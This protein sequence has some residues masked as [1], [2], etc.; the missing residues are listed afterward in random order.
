MTL[1]KARTSTAANDVKQQL[2]PGQSSALLQELHLLTRDGKLNADALRKL[3][4][5]NHL[6]GF[7][8]APIDDVFARHTDPVVVDFGSGN[9]YLGF[10]VYELMLKDK[11]AGRLLSVESRADLVL[12]GQQRA[13]RLSYARMEFVAAHIDSAALPERIHVATALHACDTATDDAM[14]VAIT[15]KADHIVM[16]PC[17]QAEVAG[18]LKAGACH[19]D[20]LFRFPH[21][22]REFGSHLTNVLRTLTLRACGY[23]VTV[24]ELVGWEHS[25][26]NELIVAKR[27]QA[28]DA[29][30]QRELLALQTRYGIAPKISRLLAAG[31]PSAPPSAC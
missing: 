11:A 18:Q 7:L 6:A 5:V 2:A 17:C 26:K 12:R 10:V 4:Q 14:H 25:L 16:V 30:A 9:G 8:R 29:D 21:H 27:V 23:Q 3:K 13:A 19:D 15:K 20:V 31:T 1:A 22:R 28:F 24:T